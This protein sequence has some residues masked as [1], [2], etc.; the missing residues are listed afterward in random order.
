MSIG[1]AK[2]PHSQ[3]KNVHVS[4]CLT[5]KL[6]K[7]ILSDLMN[8]LNQIS[9]WM[10]QGVTFWGGVKC[11]PAATCNKIQRILLTY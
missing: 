1:H 10:G 6:G 11:T 3:T 9:K 5:I 2:L 7:K 4:L 8:L